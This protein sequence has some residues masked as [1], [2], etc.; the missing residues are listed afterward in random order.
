MKIG[1]VR[2][3]KVDCSYPK[4]M[5]SHSYNKWAENYDIADVIA[6]KV[7]LHNIDWQKCYAS[8][9]PRA[10]KTAQSIYKGNITKLNSLREV[11]MSSFTDRSLKLPCTI[12][13]I[14]SR[15]AW[16]RSHK[17]QPEFK[18]E[19]LRRV[20]DSF[21]VIT[22]S[23]NENTLVVS[24]GFFLYFFQKELFKNG[25]RGKKFYKLKNGTLYVFED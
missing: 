25:F 7:D 2:H 3:F 4:V 17:S 8:D 9:L 13:S 23:N 1:L 24:H 12:W 16:L 5:N 11:P 22:E 20:K 14:A 6:N 10:I 19:T 18:H 15:L 21:K